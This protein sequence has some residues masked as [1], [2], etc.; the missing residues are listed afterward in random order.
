[1]KMAKPLGHPQS[2]FRGESNE[3]QNLM[4]P[5][6]PMAYPRGIDSLPGHGHMGRRIYA[7]L[8]PQHGR[9]YDT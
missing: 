6:Y 2:H 9:T 5:T 1:M 7:S 4:G 8:F 3:V